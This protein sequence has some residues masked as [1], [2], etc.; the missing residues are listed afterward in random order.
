[1]SRLLKVIRRYQVQ[2][3]I[4]GI[5]LFI[6]LLIYL[7]IQYSSQFVDLFRNWDKLKD[8]VESKGV[9]GVFIFI[10]FQILQVVVAAIPGEV[11]QI[12]GGY[13]FGTFWATVY[14]VIGVFIGSTIVFY[15]SRL[16]GYEFVKRIIPGDA[17]EKYFIRDN[18]KKF[19]I[20]AFILFLIPG[21]PKDVLTY[22]AGLTPVKPLRFIVISVLGRLPA[23][24][25]STIIGD[26]FENRNYTAAIAIFVSAVILFLLGTLFRDKLVNRVHAL[27]DT[28]RKQ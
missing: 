14:L 1:M 5:V 6:G 20:F 9:L 18:G 4:A 10:L 23:L 26:V 7:T 25:A 8:M 22:I 12:A 13:L 15:I 16:L 28:F 17:I 21:M 2:I 27:I 24:I 11:V 19:L 3:R